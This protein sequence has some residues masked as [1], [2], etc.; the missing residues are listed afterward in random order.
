MS[1]HPQRAQDIRRENRAILDALVGGDFKIVE[2]AV[3]A[4]VRGAANAVR[5]FIERETQH[6]FIVAA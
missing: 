1:R 4:H 2:E 5:L 6:L 3:K